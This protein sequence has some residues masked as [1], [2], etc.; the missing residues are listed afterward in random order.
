MY[1]LETKRL[2][3]ERDALAPD[4]SDVRTLLGLPGGGMA[5]FELPPGQ[6]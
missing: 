6:T 2:P 3:V 1:K 4:G 5:H